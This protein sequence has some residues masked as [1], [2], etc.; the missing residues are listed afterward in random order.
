MFASRGEA[1]RGD[2]LVSSLG[3][4]SV[5]LKEPR[6][7]PEEKLRI[8]KIIS[9]SRGTEYWQ[10][11]G[12]GEAGTVTGCF[13]FSLFFRFFFPPSPGSTSNS[14]PHHPLVSTTCKRVWQVG[15]GACSCCLE[16][17]LAPVQQYQQAL[18][19]RALS[20]FF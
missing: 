15:E 12:H 4:N 18:Q 1:S 20:L 16:E 7:T 3:L 17:E 8:S 19:L 11:Y 14:I 13:F 6:L 2:L 5:R 9:L 10:E